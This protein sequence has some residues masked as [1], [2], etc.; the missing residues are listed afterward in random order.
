ME[1]LVKN[2]ENLKTMDHRLLP[3][4]QRLPSRMKLRICH[5]DDVDYPESFMLADRDGVY[6]KRTPGRG[7]AYLYEQ[8]PRVNAE[9]ERIFRGFWER[10]NWIPQSSLY[11]RDWTPTP[12]AEAYRDLVFRQWWIHWEGRAD[13]N[14][15][16]RIRGFYGKYAVKSGG[17]TKE[18]LLSKEAGRA[19]VHFE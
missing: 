9:Y 2:A 1:I 10:A 19:T 3:L 18:V 5:A 14:G 4:I 17:Q 8:N 12:A 6:L 7:V 15:Q 11:R 13:A 16:C